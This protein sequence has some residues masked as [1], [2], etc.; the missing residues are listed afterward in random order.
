MEQRSSRK[1]EIQELVPLILEGIGEGVLAVD[2]DFRLVYL[3]AQAEAI[4]GIPREVALGRR[5]YEVL[6]ANVCQEG[7]PMRRSMESGERQQDVRVDILDSGMDTVPL[8]V[9]TAALRGADGEVLGGVEIFRDISDI[10]AL[11]G[12]LAGRKAL[13][14][15]VGTSEPMQRIFAILPDMADS[16]AP[17]LI[18]GD[19]GTGKELIGRALHDLSGRRE[20]PFVQV[21]CGALPDTLLESELFGHVRGAFTD[22]RRDKPGRFQAADGGTLMLDEVGDLSP[23]F[24]VKLLRAIQEGEVQPLGAIKPVR[25]DVR[26]ISATNKD[27]G[28]LVRNGSFREDL[29][30][31]LRVIPVRLPPLRERRD[32]ILPLLRHHIARLVARTGKPIRGLT[33][34]AEA[35][36]R[37]YDFPGNVRELVN[38]LERGFVLCHGAHIDFAHLPPEV[39][40]PRLGGSTERPTSWPSTGQLKPSEHRLRLAAHADPRPPTG[41]RGPA[42]DLRALL[43]AHSWSRSA[44]AKTLGISRTTLWRRMKDY[45]LV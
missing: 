36:L 24:Q 23:A 11:R 26:I 7:C 15:I 21:N 12:E 18:E 32:D 38:I 8:L 2:A 16:D 25:V 19:S 5:C 29:Y 34:S 31:R 37:Q 3:N 43:D 35:V 33:P 42:D 4:T 9:S 27:L 30:Y 14:D 39:T 40:S 41:L 1:P 28:Q 6:R 13:R 44:V 20:G 22:A 45:E 17:V 10:E